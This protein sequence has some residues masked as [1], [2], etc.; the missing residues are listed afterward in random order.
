MTLRT[1]LVTTI[2]GATGAKV[3]FNQKEPKDPIPATVIRIIGDMPLITVDAN[4]TGLSRARIQ[5][6]SIDDDYSGLETLVAAT[7]AAL[8]AN[9]TDFEVSLPLEIKLEDK[10]D[11]LHYSIRE[12]LIW[13]RK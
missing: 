2:E 13:Y 12:Y 1:A 7:E 9:I 5:V 3:H 6:T 8:F 4:Q 10:E 11:T